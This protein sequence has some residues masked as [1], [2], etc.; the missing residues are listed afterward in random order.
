[1]KLPTAILN[2]S[3]LPRLRSLFIRV[4]GWLLDL[5]DITVEE[6]RERMLSQPSL[7]ASLSPE[8]LESIR[9]YDGPE[10]LGPPPTRRE[11]RRAAATA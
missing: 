5:D 8:A 7:I 1:M 9:T 6:A 4:F 2:A 11:L 3:P 10:V